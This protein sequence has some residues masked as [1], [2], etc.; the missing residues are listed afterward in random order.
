MKT[1]KILTFLLFLDD[2]EGHLIIKIHLGD[3]T[4]ICSFIKIT[5]DILMLSGK[6]RIV[7]FLWLADIILKLF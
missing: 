2:K 6:N 7:S 3:E 1:L 5:W 4:H